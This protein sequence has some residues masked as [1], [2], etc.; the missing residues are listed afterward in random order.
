M[1][2]VLL[3][4][5][6]NRDVQLTDRSALPESLRD[7]PLPARMLGEEL[8]A[9]LAGYR[10]HLA[11]PMIGVTVRWLIEEQAVSPDDLYVHLFA[12]DQPEE[13]TPRPL[14]LQDTVDLARIIQRCLVDGLPT[15]ASP[16]RGRL[17]KSHVRLHT[18]RSNPAH[19]RLMLET[20]TEHFDDLRRHLGPEDEVFLE[21]TGGTPAMTSMMIVAGANTFGQQARAIYIQP[22]DDEPER[23][24]VLQAFFRRQARASLALQ[25]GLYAYE[26]AYAT[27]TNQADLITPNVDQQSLVASLLR[28]AGRRLAFDFERAREALST[29]KAVAPGDVYAHVKHWHTELNHPNDADRLGELVHSAQIKYQLGDYADFTQR[30]FRF[31]EAGFRSLAARMGMRCTDDDGEFV[32]MA[33]AH[34]VPGLLTYLADYVTHEGKRTSIDIE[35]RSLN[36]VS[37]GAIVDFYVDTDASWEHLDDLVAKLFRL[38]AFGGLRNRGLA[39]HGFRGIGKPDLTKVF[40]EDADQ[41][42]PLLETIYADLFD[43]PLGESPYVAVNRLILA[44]I[45]T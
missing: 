9:N 18:I 23:V 33:W 11:Y 5:V 10:D 32:D 39:G 40:D 34:G 45:G 29:A 36:R 38:S 22:G 27:F 26:T 13:A 35:Q 21:V 6:G 7:G 17:A 41:V 3:A 19:Y 16:S 43:R 42:V 37:L 24:G 25:I 28:Y 12:T 15:L 14:W 2:V 20:F 1:T 30:L 44:Q 31:Q 8:L 4:N